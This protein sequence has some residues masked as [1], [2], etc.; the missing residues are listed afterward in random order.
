MK[1][2]L[3]VMFLVLGLVLAANAQK[4]QRVRFARGTHSATVKGTITGYSYIDYLVGV[5]AGQTL[6]VDLSPKGKAQI[7]I[8][9]PSGDNLA[10]GD[11]VTDGSFDLDQAGDYKLRVLMPRSAARRKGAIAS[12]SLKVTVKN[13]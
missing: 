11:G 1:K 3:A 5:R 6:T 13:S 2:I 7:V 9:E 8:L 12:F 4:S 10:E